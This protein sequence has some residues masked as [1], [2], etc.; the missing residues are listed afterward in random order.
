MQKDTRESESK[1]YYRFQY[2]IKSRLQITRFENFIG[3]IL[4]LNN[5]QEKF[6]LNGGLPQIYHNKYFKFYSKR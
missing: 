1:L 6:Y 3:R 4:S 5:L 2:R